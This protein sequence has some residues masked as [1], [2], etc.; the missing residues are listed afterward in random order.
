M[1]KALLAL[2]LCLV[3]VPCMAQETP[4]LG[5]SVQGDIISGN[6]L[7]LSV[8]AGP[9]VSHSL[10]VYSEPSHTL[11]LVAQDASYASTA[12][13]QQWLANQKAATTPSA[14][15]TTTLPGAQPTVNIPLRPDGDNRISVWADGVWFGTR[16]DLQLADAMVGSSGFAFKTNLL[17]PEKKLTGLVPNASGGGGPRMQHCCSGGNCSEMC[18][19]CSGPSF[20]C[21]L[22]N[23]CCTITCGIAT[24]CCS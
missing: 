5:V 9:F 6:Y 7:R 8:Q 11:L 24:E 21:C 12:E 19:Y 15:I 2:A 13:G 1:R 17:P 3:V 20:T 4:V 23:G 14:M 18:I 22:L 10:R 16:R